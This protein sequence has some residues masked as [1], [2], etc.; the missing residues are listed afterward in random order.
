MS[1]RLTVTSAARSVMALCKLLQHGVNT[2][3][4]RLSE[5]TVKGDEV[6]MLHRGSESYRNTDRRSFEAANLTVGD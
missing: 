6:S 4:S 1:C 2:H 3:D 5:I